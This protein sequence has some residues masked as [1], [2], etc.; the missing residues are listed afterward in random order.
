MN[1]DETRAEL[2]NLKLREY[3]LG[4][5]EEAKICKLYS[6]LGVKSYVTVM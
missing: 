3:S 6:I 4:V 2:I 5:N 1:E